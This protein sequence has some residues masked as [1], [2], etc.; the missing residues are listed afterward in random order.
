MNNILTRAGD[1]AHRLQVLYVLIG[2]FAAHALHETVAS[3]HYSRPG[4]LTFDWRPGAQLGVTGALQCAIALALQCCKVPATPAWL[5]GEVISD[6][7]LAKL[8]S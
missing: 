7:I 4:H 3:L 6:F 5:I 8:Q 1:V 2:F